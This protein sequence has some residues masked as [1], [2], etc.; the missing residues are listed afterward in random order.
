LPQSIVTHPF[1]L[2]YCTSKSMMP[3]P[4]LSVVPKVSERVGG[5]WLSWKLLRSVKTSSSL[6]TRLPPKLTVSASDEY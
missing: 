3:R 6:M 5:V 2:R 1:P 4:V